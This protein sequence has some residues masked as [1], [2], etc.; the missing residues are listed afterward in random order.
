M[1]EGFG[2]GKQTVCK[3][4]GQIKSVVPHLTRLGKAW[5]IADLVARKK[6]EE[7]RKK[8]LKLLLA[9]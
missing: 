5:D 2:A 3:Q 8:I 9:I 1:R 4:L 6:K 7:R